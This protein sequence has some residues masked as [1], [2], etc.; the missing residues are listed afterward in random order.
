MEMI[1]CANIVKWY[2]IHL[3]TGFPS[4]NETII[5]IVGLSMP[6]SL[7]SYMKDTQSESLLNQKHNHVPDILGTLYFCITIAEC[8]MG[9]F[10]H[11]L[12][13]VFIFIQYW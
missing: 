1:K 8:V 7:Y 4:L 12:K 9:G 5:V 11:S 10:V 6:Y 13:I 3:K 2:K